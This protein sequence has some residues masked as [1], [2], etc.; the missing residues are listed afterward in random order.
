MDC[1]VHAIEK[2]IR[3]LFADGV[4]YEVADNLDHVV[5]E[6]TVITIRH[7]SSHFSF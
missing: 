2:A 1:Q 5:V 3:P 6:E 7:D 4:T